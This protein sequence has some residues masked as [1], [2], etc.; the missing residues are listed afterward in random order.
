MLGKTVL[1]LTLA[2]SRTPRD[3]VLASCELGAGGPWLSGWWD[4]ARA[5][6]TAGVGCFKA[7]VCAQQSVF[8]GSCLAWSL[9]PQTDVWVFAEV[10]QDRAHVVLRDQ[11][12]SL[13]A[14]GVALGMTEPGPSSGAHVSKELFHAAFSLPVGS[15]ELGTGA[16]AQECGAP[17]LRDRP[18]GRACPS[19]VAGRLYHGG[20][21]VLLV[22]LRAG[23]RIKAERTEPIS[24]GSCCRGG[25]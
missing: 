6:L 25:F 16:A 9:A 4:G 19:A 3:T 15:V 14:L 2:G 12:R 24:P 17:H 5:R 7:A 20:Q 11:P 22:T 23:A 1:C 8:C 13:S 21:R 18:V 10:R